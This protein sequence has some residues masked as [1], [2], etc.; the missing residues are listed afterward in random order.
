MRKHVLILPVK[1]RI[2]RTSGRRG[3][4][5]VKIEQNFADFLYGWAKINVPNH[6]ITLSTQ[7][8]GR[9]VSLILYPTSCGVKTIRPFISYNFFKLLKIP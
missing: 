1:G 3:G 7:S 5:V 4:G 2:L 9:V 6:C 8:P